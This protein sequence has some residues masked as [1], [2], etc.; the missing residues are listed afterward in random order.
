[1]IDNELAYSSASDLVRLIAA[2]EVSPVELTDLFFRRIDELDPQL[3]S[4]L[5][6]TRDE[7]IQTAR[8]AEDAVMRGDELGPLHG[9]PIAIKDT[10]M[11]KGVR[12]TFGSLLFKDRVPERDAGIVERI[13][14][15][16]GIMLGKTNTSEFALI[17]MC[18][19]RLG[20][21]G[22]NP[23]NTGYTPGGSSGGSG[24]ALAAYLC[25]LATGGDGGGSIRIPA[26][27]CGIYGIKPTQGRVSG[28]TGV[29]GPP[30]PNLFGQQGPMSR[31]VRDSAL[32][33]QVMAGYD[34]RDPN[35][36]R[37]APPDFVA[38]VDRDIKG[39]RIGWSPD[40]GFAAVD[41]EVLAVTSRAVQVF[42]ELGCQLED[43]DLVM[44]SPYEAFGP[45]I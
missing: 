29:E 40:Y 32:L 26:S 31:T 12:T 41:P 28:Y 30:M 15:A 39:L 44:D 16:G 2:K 42:E 45:H 21:S 24:A 7:A 43:S 20:D 6:L 18:D 14:G 19:N 27:L 23:W 11:T 36:L 35:S 25:P 38:A 3:N 37:D 4:F 8:A 17:G 9:L 5:L 1:M 22:R 34:P 13:K 10:H 33:L